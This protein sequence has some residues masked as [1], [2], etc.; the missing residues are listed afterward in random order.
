MNLRP[1][2]ARSLAR[3]LAL[4]LLPA[5]V[6]GITA[7]G[8]RGNTKSFRAG[9]KCEP[10]SR[11]CDCQKTTSHLFGYDSEQGNYFY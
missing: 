4:A 10:C 9:K 11:K 8:R 6:A 1:S 7:V 5:S 3:F 2:L